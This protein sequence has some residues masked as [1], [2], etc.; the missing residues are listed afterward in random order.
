MTVLSA[1]ADG[2]GDYGSG[3]WWDAG[4]Y[5]VRRDPLY[6]VALMLVGA[7]LPDKWDQP[8]RFKFCAEAQFARLVAEVWSTVRKRFTTRSEWVRADNNFVGDHDIWRLPQ[9]DDTW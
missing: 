3:G 5:S 4:D 2:R 8:E 6:T 9:A 1:D 7:D